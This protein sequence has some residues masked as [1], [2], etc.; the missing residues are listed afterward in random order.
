MTI[1]DQGDETKIMQSLMAADCSDKEI[2]EQARGIRDL[3][4]W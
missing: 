2:E 4:G 3:N 1:Q